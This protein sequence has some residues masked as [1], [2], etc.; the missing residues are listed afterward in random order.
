MWLILTGE[1][2]LL[3]N[4]GGECMLVMLEELDSLE[5]Q[6]TILLG[7][8]FLRAYYT[9]YDMEANKIGLVPL[10]QDTHELQE[11]M[12][13]SDLIIEMTKNV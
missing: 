8:P 9:I 7:D 12:A 6:H 2:Y 1:D 4:I 10:R 13:K 3:N 5:G 11:K